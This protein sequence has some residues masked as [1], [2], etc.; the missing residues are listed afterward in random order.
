MRRTAVV[1]SA[2][3]ALLIAGGSATAASLITSS[4]IKD[5]SIQNRDIKKKAI[6]M[7][8]LAQT[9][10]DKINKAGTPGPKGNTGATGA[11]GDPGAPG[12]KGDPGAPGPKGDPG[13]PA[14]TEFGVAT[15]YVDRGS[16]PKRWAG[17]SVP[18]GSP[19]GTTTSGHF[20]FQCRP[21]HAPPCEV[22]VGA[23]VINTAGQT[24]TV[25]FYPRITIHK[26][27]AAA[28]APAPMTFCEAA[29]GAN[30]NLG[31][32]Q[33]ARVSTVADAVIAMRTP[34]SMGIGSTADCGAGQTAGSSVK[35]ILVPVGSLST[36]PAQYDVWVTLGFG[37]GL[38]TQPEDNG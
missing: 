35:E 22:S 16:G 24:G 27:D 15:V 28:A 4:D 30:N 3:V 11:K 31:V 18:L 33:V 12:P 20:R 36:A 37:P 6:T 17:Y 7:S 10:Q 2:L 25:P 21:E 26:E 32:D 19:A 9:T 14:A 29:D 13:A 5:E 23:A 1:V 38:V 8:R 34:L